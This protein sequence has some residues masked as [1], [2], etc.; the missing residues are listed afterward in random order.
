MHAVL[1]NALPVELRHLAAAST[2]RPQPYDHLCAA[3][4]ACYGHTYRPHWWSPCGTR[5][6][7]AF[8]RPRRHYIDYDAFYLVPATGASIPVQGHHDKVEDPPTSTDLPIERSVTL[9]HHPTPSPTST[10]CDTAE[11]SDSTTA[12][13]PRALESDNVIVSS[14]VRHPITETSPSRMSHESDLPSTS[15][16]CASWK[17]RLPSSSKSSAAEVPARDQQRPNFGD[18][19]AMT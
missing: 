7:A 9:A 4:L 1:L 18:A 10:A 13:L 6:T 2:S 12:T 16:F 19:A 3:V 14:A 5:R 8:T 11:T 17:K 15:T